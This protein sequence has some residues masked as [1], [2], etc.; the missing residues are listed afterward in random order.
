M[1]AE[2]I[3][4]D[5]QVAIVTGAGHG[6]GRAYATELAARGATVVCND[7]AGDAAAAAAL[8]IREL[9]GSAVAEPSSVA[10][11][12]GGAA[13]VASAIERFGR[14]DVVVNN[15]GQ[16]R[17]AAFEEL[18][19]EHFSAVLATH[20]AGAFHVTQPAFRYMESAGYGRIVFTSSAAV[21]G[22]PWQA[23]YAAAKAGVIGL[24][25]VVALEG[26]S[27]GIVAN[28]ILP[29]AA[30]G[31]GRDGPPQFTPEDLEATIR[32]LGPLLPGMTVENVAP[33]A[34][35]LASRECRVTGRAFSVGARHVAEVFLGLTDGWYATGSAFTPE[36][37]ASQL[38]AICDRS[39]FTVPESMNDANRSIAAQVQQHVQ[40]IGEG[41]S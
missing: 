13:I 6:L 16:L 7:F 33:V 5:G 34:V 10:D 14:V 41:E 12:A 37:V 24:C 3:R 20:L 29:M 4:F 38:D 31:I 15:A 8:E 1:G 27:H 17:N 36:T 2:S 22:S 25:N 18:T 26:A 11:P 30:T 35:Y 28:A 21:F 23:N 19:V 39:H 40:P 9:G 32:S